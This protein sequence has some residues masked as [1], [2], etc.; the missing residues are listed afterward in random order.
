MLCSQ[1]KL[2]YITGMM[3]TEKYAAIGE[4]PEAPKSA[5]AVS[6]SEAVPSSRRQRESFIVEPTTSKSRDIDNNHDEKVSLY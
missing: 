2:L 6:A 4:K 3:C 1:I 5:E